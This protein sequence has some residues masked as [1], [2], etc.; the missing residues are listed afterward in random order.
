MNLK[1]TLWKLMQVGDCGVLDQ[2]TRDAAKEAHLALSELRN[3]LD[4]PATAS[5][6]DLVAA[7]VQLKVT[8]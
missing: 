2:Q 3:V 7:V 1:D 4:L 8:F 6:S 5:P